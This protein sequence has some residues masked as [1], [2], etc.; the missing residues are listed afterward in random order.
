MISK[1]SW[2]SP[3]S[4]RDLQVFPDRS[5]SGPEVQ[6]SYWQVH[7]PS[8]FAVQPPAIRLEQVAPPLDEHSQA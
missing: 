7:E 8:V 3:P 6:D 4:F 1:K 5:I 2:F